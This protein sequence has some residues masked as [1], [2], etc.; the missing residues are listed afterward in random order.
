MTKQSGNSRSE[1]PERIR[2]RG[3]QALLGASAM[4]LILTAGTAQA[5]ENPFFGLY[6]TPGLIDMPNADMAPDGTLSTTFSYFAGTSRNTLTFQVLPRLT[7][8]FR[9]TAIQDLYLRGWDRDTYYDRSFDMR[10]QLFSETDWR[11]AVA[12][13]LQDFI[14]TGLY[15]GE[16]IVASKHIGKRLQLTG[17]V[18]WGRLGSHGTIG[19]T[20]TRPSEVIGEGGIPT[21]DRWFRGDFAAFGGIAWHAT[22]RLTLKA[23]YSSDAYDT[24]Q[25]TGTNSGVIYGPVFERKSPWNFGLD[26]RTRNGTQ[27]SLYSLYGSEFG[28]LVTFHSN[29]RTGGYPS[30][31]ETAPLPVRVRSAAERGD[32]GWHQDGTVVNSVQARLRKSLASQGLKYEGLNLTPRRATLRLVNTRYGDEPEAIGRAARSMSRIL[33]GSV[34]TFVIVPVVEGIPMSAITL[35]R[36][37]LERYEN[38]PAEQMLGRIGVEDGLGRAPA[39]EEG[40]GTRF[41]WSVS[42]YMQLSVFDPD[43]PVRYDLGIRAKAA[44]RITP[45]M[46]LAGSLAKKLNGNLDSVTREIPSGLARVRTD[47]A[48]YSRQGDPALEYL[49]LT[50]FGRPGKDLYSRVSMGYLETMY[51]GVSGELLWKPVGSRL[52]LGAELNYVQPRDF[53]QMFGLRSRVTSSGTI[54]EFNGHLSAYYDF[55]NG[56]HGQLD[57]GSYLAGDLGATVSLDRE[58]AN[59]WTVGAYATFTTAEIDDF[60]EGSFDKGIRITIP[61]AW[62]FGKPSRQ[63]NN[64]NIQ[65]LTRDGGA[66]LN[67][68]DRLYPLVRDYHQ[69]EL[70]REWGRF[71]R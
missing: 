25:E 29:P 71:W 13:G 46:V 5:E 53:D 58:F 62:A 48:E 10:Y 68:N 32:L 52:A 9:Y 44:Y 51:A 1:R 59:G 61:F 12:V 57:V 11:P 49:T 24:E 8:S 64:L 37:D 40:A 33:P 17:G 3:S 41:S 65:S 22:D 67:L 43:N 30:G 16:Y 50:H 20:G 4:A 45:N 38:A 54:P 27:L 15:G 2:R 6:G 26:Y 42:P 19:S 55:G 56:F 36:S 47:Y 14:G 28:A 66:R 31:R 39:L 35:N 7:A 63:E 70:A 23:E 21:Y 34:E 18:G 60:G 69:P